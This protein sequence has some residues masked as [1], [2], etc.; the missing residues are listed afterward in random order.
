MLKL[1]FILSWCRMN[2]LLLFS[3]QGPL[4][5]QSKLYI[6]NAS[7]I[8][9][10]SIFFGSSILIRRERLKIPKSWP[11]IVM[12]RNIWWP[13]QT[14]ISFVHRFF[15][16]AFLFI[17]SLDPHLFD[18]VV[19][20][21]S[22]AYSVSMLFTYF[23]SGLLLIWWWSISII[24]VFFLLICRTT[25]LIVYYC[26]VPLLTQN[27]LVIS[28]STLTEVVLFSYNFLINDIEHN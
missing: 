9:R 15:P 28:P 27:G 24:L 4:S 23:M 16:I 1:F 11:I 12:L 25:S 22:K 21:C 2:C 8:F 10:L 18:I 26:L 13:F 5:N 17:S 20:R 7:S 14:L 3:A 19:S 6:S